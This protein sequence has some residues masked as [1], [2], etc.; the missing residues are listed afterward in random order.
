MK[1]FGIVCLLQT[2]TL[3]NYRTQNTAASKKTYL[4]KLTL[5]SSS[6]FNNTVSRNFHQEARITQRTS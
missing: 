4:P 5:T 3:Y 2:F 1:K 6:L